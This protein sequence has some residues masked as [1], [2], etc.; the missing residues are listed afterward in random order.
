MRAIY[1]YNVC[2]PAPL[3]PLFS[4]PNQ[5]LPDWTWGGYAPELRLG[6]PELDT[7]PGKIGAGPSTLFATSCSRS[8]LMPAQLT[9]SLLGNLGAGSIVLFATRCIRY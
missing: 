1:I 7:P 2:M 5:F 4:F 8:I 9:F 3:P 6:P